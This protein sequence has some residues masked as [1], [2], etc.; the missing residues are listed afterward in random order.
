MKSAH[1]L[2]V[3]PLIITI[4]ITICKSI[5]TQT[6]SMCNLRLKNGGDG[7]EFVGGPLHCRQSLCREPALL[8]QHPPLGENGL[9]V[10]KIA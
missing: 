2:H 9:G 10:I 1:T 5:D 3:S 6:W 4:T 8:F 7:V